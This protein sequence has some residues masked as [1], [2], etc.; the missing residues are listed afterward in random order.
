MLGHETVAVRIDVLRTYMQRLLEA[1]GFDREAAAVVA[2]VHL[3]SDLRGVG[4]QGF[5][6]LINSHLQYYRKGEADPTAR[7]VIVREKA[8]FA[9]IDGNSGPGPLAALLAADVAS[10]KAKDAGC[11]VVGVRNS[12][13]LFHAGLYAERMANRDV[14]GMVFSDDVVPVVHPVGGVEPIIGSNP[15]AFSVPTGSTPFL[16]DFTPCATLPTY[17]RY[18]RRYQGKLPEG[19]AHDRDGHSTRDPDLV[20]D[21]LDY[22]RDIG[23]IDPG[24]HKGYGLLLLIDFLSGALVGCDMGVDHVEKEGPRKG[25]L[26]IA[27]D[28]EI[29]GSIEDFKH[30]VGGRIEAVKSSR[31]AP[32]VQD[33]RYP[34]EGSAT[35][36]KRALEDG[37]VW[38]DCHCWED[39]LEIGRQ[40]GVTPP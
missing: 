40:L 4:V 29:F 10:T 11:A 1:V 25:H 12:H 37:E 30:S 2:D 13:D 22:T 9:L 19:V 24:G 34:G 14:I 15:M 31:K 6:H 23:A 39:G 26:F 8:C 5:N 27:I 16:S 33:I 18:S 36:R 17:V 20:C 21:G 38:I 28:P 35:R 3:E 7:P 32:G